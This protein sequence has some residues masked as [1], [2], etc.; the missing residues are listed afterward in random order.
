VQGGATTRYGYGRTIF[1]GVAFD[2]V[3]IAD[4]LVFRVDRNMPPQIIFNRDLAVDTSGRSAST[5]SPTELLAYGSQRPDRYVLIEQGWPFALRADLAGLDVGASE[6]TVGMKWVSLP[7][8]MAPRLGSGVLGGHVM[9]GRAPGTYPLEVTVTAPTVIVVDTFFV[10]V[11]PT[12]VPWVQIDSLSM[13]VADSTQ[14]D[15]VLT[16][17]EYRTVFLTLRTPPPIGD[18]SSALALRVPTVQ[19]SA[20]VYQLTAVQ[21]RPIAANSAAHEIRARRLGRTT[22]CPELRFTPLDAAI[23]RAQCYRVRVEP[24]PSVSPP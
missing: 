19:D 11:K 20:G 2:S 15:I 1:K 5:L 4:T 12:P 10:V 9:I 22:L 8:D 23:V 21:V 13:P 24:S 3:V 16:L 14:D 7:L 18:L 17:G 6:L